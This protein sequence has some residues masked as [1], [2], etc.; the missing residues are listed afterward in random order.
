[1]NKKENT[2]SEK[3]DKSDKSDKSIKASFIQR[4]VAYVIDIFLISFVA[5]IIAGPFVDVNSLSKLQ[6]SLSEVT[7]KAQNLEISFQTFIVESIPLTYKIARISGVLTL[8][9][10]FLTAVYFIVFQLKCNGQTIGKKLVKIKVVSVDGELD[11]NQMLLRSLIINEI[12]IGM[13]AF[14]LMIFATD[15]IYYYG[16]LVLEMIQYLIILISAGM[17]FFSKNGRGLHD[18]ISHTEVVQEKNRGVLK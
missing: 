18:L 4:L 1:M 9:T 12:L 2:E 16:T 11:V 7:M 10:L 13:V 5:S 15:D 17:V 6:E 14:G 3:S 8:V